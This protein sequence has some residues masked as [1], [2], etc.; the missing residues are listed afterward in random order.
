MEKN[1]MQGEE[2]L[3]LP[4]IVEKGLLAH[5]SRMLWLGLFGGLVIDFLSKF[6]PFLNMEQYCYKGDSNLFLGYIGLTLY[7]L[8]CLC[9]LG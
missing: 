1:P 4:S 3:M 6:I 7:S 9:N 5:L 8:I 2:S